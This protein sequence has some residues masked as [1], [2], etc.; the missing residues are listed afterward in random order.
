MFSYVKNGHFFIKKH[1]FDIQNTCLKKKRTKSHQLQAHQG[2][3]RFLIFLRDIR[4][5]YIL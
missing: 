1:T 5:K 3:E 4:T 2:I